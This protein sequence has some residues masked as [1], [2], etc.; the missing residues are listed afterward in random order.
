MNERYTGRLAVLSAL[1]AALYLPQASATG[2]NVNYHSL[3]LPVASGSDFKNTAVHSGSF[4][5]VFSFTV[6][7]K[8]DIAGSITSGFQY[9]TATG[10]LSTVPSRASTAEGQLATNSA[11]AASRLARSAA[12]DVALQVGAASER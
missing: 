9:V 8:A 11:G 7:H 5:D 3:T 12:I 1:L 4:S 2:L 6:G 10:S